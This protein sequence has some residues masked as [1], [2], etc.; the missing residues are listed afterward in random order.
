MGSGAHK[1][2]FSSFTAG[3]SRPALQAT[4]SQLGHGERARPHRPR[5]R[6][7]GAEAMRSAADARGVVRRGGG[8]AGGR[9]ALIWAFWEAGGGRGG[10]DG[11][12]VEEGGGRERERE[13]GEVRGEGNGGRDNVSR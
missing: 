8:L 11:R 1:S 9:R 10:V 6:K 12:E 3:R 13:E 2:A 7:E 4:G 5:E